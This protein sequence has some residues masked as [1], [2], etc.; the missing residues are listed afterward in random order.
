MT[1]SAHFVVVFHGVINSNNLLD[2]KRISL[3]KLKLRF[4]DSMSS[5]SDEESKCVDDR[6]GDINE[7]YARTFI[8]CTG[9]VGIHRQSIK[10]CVR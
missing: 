3:I 10:H 6:K 5:S 7:G 2:D 1:G 8:D 9:P 4:V